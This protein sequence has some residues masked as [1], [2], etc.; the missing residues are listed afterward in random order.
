MNHEVATLP[1]G[2]IT[3]HALKLSLVKLTS[4]A[5]QLFEEVKNRGTGSRPFNSKNISVLIALCQARSLGVRVMVSVKI[6]GAARDR[7][8]SKCSAMSPSGMTQTAKRRAMISQPLL[9][10]RKRTL[11]A[12]AQRLGTVA[13]GSS[14]QSR[15][16]KILDRLPTPNAAVPRQS[17]DPH[18]S[19]RQ[20]QSDKPEVKVLL[21]SSRH[22]KLN[23]GKMHEPLGFEAS[24]PQR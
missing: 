17:T 18:L 11:Q 6:K 12:S 2:A 15:S 14:G 23:S 9:L 1:L 24:G 13:P 22:L 19:R 20:V 7:S 3:V 10:P 4:C 21:V 8:T 5:T 16:G